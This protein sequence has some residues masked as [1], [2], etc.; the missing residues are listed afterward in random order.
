MAIDVIVSGPSPVFVSVTPLCTPG[1]PARNAVPNASTVGGSKA[2][3]GAV[4]V[5]VNGTVRWLPAAS[6]LMVSVPGR[7]PLA[8]GVSCTVTWQASPGASALGQCE[9]AASAPGAL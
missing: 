9:I 5:P 3:A 4:P 7:G 8:A 2:T 6:S 1:M